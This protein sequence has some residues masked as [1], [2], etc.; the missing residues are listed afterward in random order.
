MLDTAH[1]YFLEVV[2]TGS[3]K[4]AAACLHVA[5]SAVSRQIAKLEDASGTPLFERRPH[6]MVPTQAGELLAGYA[7]RTAL[8]AQR[9]RHELRSLRHAERS[10]IRIGANEAAGRNLLP[11][12]MAAWRETHPEVAFQVL[13]GAPG[14]LAQRLAEG[15]IDIAVAFSLKT[16]S[17]VT[18]RHEIDSPVRALMAPDH[19]LARRAFVSLDD[20]RAYP[21]ALT[22]AGATVKLLFDAASGGLDGTPFDLAYSSNSSSVIHAVVKAGQAITL[23]GEITLRAALARG[24][25][26][27]VPLAEAG[28]ALRTLQVQTAAGRVLPEAAERFIGTLIQALQAEAD[29]PPVAQVA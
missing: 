25:L 11:G 21:I 17:G 6:G 19:P 20:L 28:F 1:R 9:V 5:A 14:V 23:S 22:D 24:E 12:I 7:R 18:V 2:R 10:T 26:V 3:I 8:E 29:A 4:E 15:G 13:V 27:A 16:A